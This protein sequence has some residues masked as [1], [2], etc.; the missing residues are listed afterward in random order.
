[1]RIVRHS[2]WLYTVVLLL[3]IAVSP[4]CFA[5]S[6]QEG[7]S[8]PIDIP[9]L[10]A[11][12]RYKYVEVRKGLWKI[13]DIS[14]P[15]KN[16]KNLIIFLENNPYNKSLRISFRLGFLKNPSEDTE[17]KKRLTDLSKRFKP[18]EF[19][20]SGIVLFVVT[21]LPADKVDKN[22]LENLIKEVGGVSDQSYSELTEFIALD[23]ES[24]KAGFGAGAPGGPNELSPS[25]LKTPDSP[26]SNTTR[27]VDSKPVLLNSVRP[28]YTEVARKNKT[29][30]TVVLRVLVDETGTV[31]TIRVLS[32]LPDGLNEQAI[33]AAKKAKFK[34]AL[35]DARAVEYWINLSITFALH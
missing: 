6:N 18:T 16:L 20:L 14:Y 19:V 32:G 26:K 21:E 13:P 34:P 29:Q 35:K 9:A 22:A 5:Q 8:T 4:L 31:K 15:G 17:F 25:I 1:M 10:I 12:T 2:I 33:E 24:G 23:L 27:D 7:R 11:E 3:G 28:A 30:G